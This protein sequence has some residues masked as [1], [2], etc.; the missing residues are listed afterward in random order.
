MRRGWLALWLM[1]PLLTWAQTRGFD[2]DSRDAG[3]S[4][5][6]QVQLPEYP[7]AENYLPLQASPMSSFDFFVDAKSVSVGKDGVV[8]YSMIAKSSG[9]LN[10]SF[11]GM[12]CSERQ[13]RIYAFG[14]TDNTWSEARSSAW[15]A[16]P[17]DFRNNQRAVLYHD[18]FCPAGGIIYTPEEGVQALKAGGHPHA[19]PSRF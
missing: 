14:R 16:M 7:K 8:R 2:G 17:A 19:T 9:A 13:F 11:E 3:R 5:E 15:Q 18:F 10:I 4:Q 12:R 6:V 1:L